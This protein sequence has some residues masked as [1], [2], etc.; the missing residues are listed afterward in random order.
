MV[1]ENNHLSIKDSNVLKGFALVLL[2]IH[3]LFGITSTIGLYDDYVVGNYELVNELGKRGKLCVAIFVFLSGYGLTRQAE[4]RGGIASI[5][6]FYKHRLLKL[7]INYWFIWLIFVPIGIFV[8]G[9]TLES[10]YVTNIGIKTVIDV[11]GLAYLFGYYG[12]NE[13]W[14][15]MSCI[16][17]LYLIFPFLYRLE[18]NKKWLIFGLFYSVFSLLCIYAS[19]PIWEYSITFLVG[20]ILGITGFRLHSGRVFFYLLI[21]AMVIL[22]CFRNFLFDIRILVDSIFCVAICFLFSCCR[23]EILSKLHFGYLGKHSMNIFMFHT[24]I[25]SHWFKPQIYCTRNPVVIFVVLLFLCIVISVLLEYLKK[26]LGIE[27][28]LKKI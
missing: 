23:I 16:I 4:Q 24:F 11:L 10:S 15:F 27:K 21:S 5:C 1:Q 12:Y 6:E 28:I 17:V 22:F 7:F 26:Y 13:T 9:R 2:L 18:K 20:N 19:R 8:F 25:F 14:W 3:H